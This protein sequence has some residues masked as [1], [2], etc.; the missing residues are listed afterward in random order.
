RYNDRLPYRDQE[1]ISRRRIEKRIYT[2]ADR[3]YIGTSLLSAM[4]TSVYRN[5]G[6]VDPRCF[7]EA[8]QID[9]TRNIF[10]LCCP[11]QGIPAG[12]QFQQPVAVRDLLQGRCGRDPCLYKIGF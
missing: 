2:G 5:N 9:R 8:K 10:G 4:L 1:R 11:P 3:E 6:A 12:G 7:I